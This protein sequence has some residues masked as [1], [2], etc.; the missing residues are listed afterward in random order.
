VLA[1]KNHASPTPM[2]SALLL[3][4]LISRLALGA[5]SVYFF[6]RGGVLLVWWWG[7]L[8]QSR[9]LWRLE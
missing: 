6:L 3:G 9:H 5:L 7:L 2:S 8:L 1:V 4:L